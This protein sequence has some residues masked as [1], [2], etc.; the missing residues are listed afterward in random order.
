MKKH[1]ENAILEVPCDLSSTLVN[2]KR[3][4]NDVQIKD[5]SQY[6]IS[7][8]DLK[9]FILSIIRQVLEHDIIFKDGYI[10][11]WRDKKISIPKDETE[12]QQYICNTIENYCKVR[13]INL[14]REVHEANGNV[15]IL[16]SYS[17]REQTNLKVCVE[18]KKAH[19]QD[20]ETAIQTQL[21][22]YM[23]SVKTQSGIY[24][25]V[26]FKNDV[27]AQPSKYKNKNILFDKINQNNPS[28]LSIDTVI[29][30]CTKKTSPSIIK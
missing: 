23:E 7:A 6:I 9:A 20:V 8:D 24:L 3:L 27:F 28:N 30:D 5:P 25:V 10:N 21:P 19:H 15:D 2:V 22:L 14:S 26:W 17:N 12:I 16:F 4:I 13:G 1:D 18:I 29:I 11:F